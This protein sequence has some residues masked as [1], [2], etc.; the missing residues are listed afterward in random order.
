MLENEIRLLWL[1]ENY[2]PQ[3]GGMAQSCDRIIRNL[4][5]SGVI[6]DIVH[7]T[8]RNTSFKITNQVK[9]T[10]LNVPFNT[11]EAHTVNCLWNFIAQEAQYKFCTHIVA[12]GGYLPLLT[13]PVFSKWLSLPLVC[14]FRGNDFDNAI[15]SSRKLPILERA[16]NQAHT[17]ATVASEMQDKIELLYPEKKVKF[18]PNSIESTNWQALKSDF[19]FAEKF[20]AKHVEDSKLA[21]GLFGHLKAK[22]GCDFL[23]K[24]IAKSGLSE[25]IHLIIVGERETHIDTIV[26]GYNLNTTFLPFLDRYE[27]IQYYLACDVI[28]LPSFYDGMPNVLLEASA[29]GI[30]VL[31]SSVGGMR[32]VL[33][34]IPNSFVFHPGDES[35]CIETLWKLINTSADERKKIGLMQKEVLDSNFTSQHETEAFLS[36]FKE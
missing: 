22:K 10:Y 36:I 11:D 4:R 16:I 6:V 9:G 15:F 8:R 3:R 32:D 30:P 20:R 23:L 26:A 29:L 5:N 2:P 17:I 25:K 18:I 14:L 7:F 35:S 34:D 12:F 31:A 13:A 33:V 24:S 28:A 19:E 21:I 1:T 27:L